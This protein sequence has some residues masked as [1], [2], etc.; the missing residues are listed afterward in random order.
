MS[1]G[2]RLPGKSLPKVEDILSPKD[3]LAR[4]KLA[5]N[6]MLAKIEVIQEGVKVAGKL[7]DFLKVREETKG[8][9]EKA[10]ADLAKAYADLETART[11]AGVSH[12]E[13]DLLEARQ[14]VVIEVLQ[15]TLEEA[16]ASTS[17]EDRRRIVE[18]ANETLKRLAE[19]SKR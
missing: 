13:L 1:S 17:F 9:I 16:R 7:L 14:N 19:V 4:D 12:R 11:G 3:Q 8:R 10:R 15:L 5:S 2:I 18:Q 6:E